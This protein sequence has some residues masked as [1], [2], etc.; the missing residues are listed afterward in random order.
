MMEGDGIYPSPL[1]W[2]SADNDTNGVDFL[3]RA[4][5]RQN[6]GVKTLRHNRQV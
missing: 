4:T 3:A 1:S 5:I 6:G 2:K